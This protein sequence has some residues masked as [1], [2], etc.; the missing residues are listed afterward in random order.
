MSNTIAFG[1]ANES[2]ILIDGCYTSL[3]PDGVRAIGIAGTRD[4]ISMELT[5]P[6]TIGEE[7][8]ISF[9]T[10][11]EV[12][13]R[14]RG[15][16]EVGCSTSPTAF[17]TFLY[18]ATTV[19]STWV[20][21]VFTFTATEASTY[22]TVRN[23][24]GDIHWNHV[25]HF[26]MI[27]PVDE[28]EVTPTDVTCFGACDGSA[29]VEEGDEPPYTYL[30]DAAAGGATTATVTDLCAGDYSV[31]VTNGT[32]EEFDLDVT[33]AEPAEIT[34]S[35]IDQTPTSCF[36][37]ADGTVNVEAAGGVGAI[38]YDIGTG[39]MATGEFTGLAAGD[40]TITITDENGCTGTVDV[41]I[42][43]PLPVEVV[44]VATTA[45]SCF[46]DDD[47]TIE[48][49]GVG[50]TGDYTYSIDGGLLGTT[51][52]FEDLSAGTYTISILDE[53]GCIN[54]MD[55]T[56]GEP[57]AVG[58]DVVAITDAVCNSESTG[59][60]EIE[61]FG[62]VGGYEHAIDGGAFSVSGEFTGLAAA[63]YEV[64]VRDANGC[65]FSETLTIAEPTAIVVDA[66]SMG[67]A[68]EGDCSG[69]ISL[70]ASGGIPD[71]TYSIDDCATSSAS[72]EFT[73]L[74]PD[75][76]TLCVTDANGCVYSD[77]VNVAEGVDPF[78]P[79]LDPIAP[80]CLDASPVT[81]TGGTI[82]MLSGTGVV[83]TTFDPGAA[84][85]GTH[86]ITN[87]ITTGC[88]G[89]STVFVTVN[90]LP[91][92][93][94][95][96]TE[97]SGCAP[98]IADFT[99][100]GTPGVSCLWNFGDGQT[101]TTCGAAS[102]NYTSAGLYDV[103][104]TITDANGCSNAVTYTDYM[105]I[106]ELPDAD[107]NFEPFA[108]TTLDP[109]VNFINNSFG[110]TSVFWTFENTGTSDEENP[111]ISFPREA[112]TYD[113]TLEAFASNGCTQSI[114]KTVTVYEEPK[115]YAPNVF[116]PDGDTYNEVFLPYLAGNDVYNYH[117]TIFNKW[118][119]IMF[120]SYDQTKGWDGTYG[121]VLVQNGTY[122]W[123]I[124]TA[125]IRT[126][127]KRV[128]NGHVTILK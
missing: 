63:D 72:S 121:G 36:G 68:C 120:E 45:V 14:V 64:T 115:I 109:T 5:G 6:L 101:S 37:S 118:G 80:L 54:S 70:V 71:Y 122:I 32:G 78:D 100:T 51:T 97:T 90:P 125:D 39:P 59:A 99:N 25:D 52:L 84:G 4:E 53:N 123:Q 65:M 96:A 7:Y 108:P 66:T 2:D 58:F 110:E 73:G 126:D 102:N 11:S 46:G 31:T 95:A 88:G 74:C 27:V 10:Y 38:T 42:T 55:I 75:D 23:V 104:L 9:W 50:G 87:T 89:T 94:F 35:I 60:L 103:T 30:W 79:T 69:S 116:T 98:F 41:T 43:E 44:E 33:I 92:V 29:T 77:I 119:E 47:G 12:T 85:V 28:L 40:Y 106:Q 19:E 82:D 17:G 3:I 22:I 112:G 21:H 26:E 86:G 83:G 128:Y 8:T 13:F 49:D 114:S 20:N 24:A 61:G 56:V 105:N 62:G 76:Y 124:T 48:V 18:T 117:L 1:A 127:E 67:E 15:D 93:S 57:T 34:G 16:V 111:T 113:V 107:F 81:I 91:S